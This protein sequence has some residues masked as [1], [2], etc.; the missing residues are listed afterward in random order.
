MAARWWGSSTCRRGGRPAPSPH[1]ASGLAPSLEPRA[2]PAPP[3]P[4]LAPPPDEAEKQRRLDQMKRRATGLLVGAGVVDVLPRVLEPRFAGVGFI[5]AM[6][7]A[8]MIGGL[9]DWFAV[10]ALF[11]HPLGI[12]IPH[13]A[14]IPARRG[15][16]IDS[17]VTMVEEDWL[18]PDVIGGR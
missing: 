13:T 1:P 15:K 16:I 4:Q 18:S 9:A 17:I 3:A 8:A 11:R 6:A 2:E 12:P 5:R 10:T 14:I 7:E